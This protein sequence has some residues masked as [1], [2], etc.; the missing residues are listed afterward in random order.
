MGALN[1]RRADA[2]FWCAIVGG[3]VGSTTLYVAHGDYQDSLIARDLLNTGVAATAHG[4]EVWS[5]SCV[6]ACWE[7]D[8]VRAIVQYPDVERLV[9]LVAAWPDPAYVETYDE[10]IPAT[11]PA[12]AGTFDVVYDPRDPDHVMA[13]SEI[14]D[15]ADPVY[16]R[17]GVGVGAFSVLWTGAWTAVHVRRNYGARS[18][19]ATRGRR[20]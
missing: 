18:E 16:W 3:I 5:S 10:W 1:Y 7:D 11:E 2:A 17:T 4:A 12:Y 8:E 15:T 6:K 9:T 13:T 20:R 14:A 19:K